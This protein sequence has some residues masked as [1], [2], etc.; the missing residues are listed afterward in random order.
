MRSRMVN[1]EKWLRMAA[2]Q[3][4]EDIELLEGDVL[5]RKK[6]FYFFSKPVVG[7]NQVDDE[8]LVFTGEMLLLDVFFQ[9]HCYQ[10]GFLV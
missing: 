9:S 1:V 3:N 6:I 10:I 2:T 5:S 4:P 8:L 7:E